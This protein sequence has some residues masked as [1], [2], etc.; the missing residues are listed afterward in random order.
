MRTYHRAARA[1]NAER[2]SPRPSWVVATKSLVVGVLIGFIPIA[3]GGAVGVVFNAD[4]PVQG[5]M[6][7]ALGAS[8]GV[9]VSLATDQIANAA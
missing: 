9:L 8:V 5:G 4:K 1:R 6:T 7:G 3:A 2:D